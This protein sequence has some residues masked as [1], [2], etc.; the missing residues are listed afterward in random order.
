M[1]LSFAFEIVGL[2]LKRYVFIQ[3]FMIKYQ[4]FSG[5]YVFEFKYIAHCIWYNKLHA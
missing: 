2:K 1:Y 5:I 4:Q 3:Q